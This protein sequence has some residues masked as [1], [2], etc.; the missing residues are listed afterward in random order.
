MAEHARLSPSGAEKWMTCPGSVA[1]EADEPDTSNDYSDEGTAAHFLA[2]TCLEM[3]NNA[4]A[5][6]GQSISVFNGKGDWTFAAHKY[7]GVKPS[8]TYTIDDEM[9]AYVQLY[10]D[11]VRE[12]A[13]GG[14]LLVEQ[15]MSISHLTGEE[16]AA[17]TADAVI[18]QGDEI[19]IA[20]LKY[21]MREVDGDRNKQ[22]MVYALAALREYELL[23]DFTTVRTVIKIGRAHV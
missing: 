17:G 18:L 4:V 8:N 5:F 20:D 6:K 1:L 2:S 14:T 21:G 11:K 23:G 9:A 3:L 7:P 10:L 12:Y 16:N 19:I 15:R 22:M 13:D